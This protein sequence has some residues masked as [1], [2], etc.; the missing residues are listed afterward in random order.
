MAKWTE[1]LPGR[2]TACA[3][4]FV[5]AEGK[6]AGRGETAGSCLPSLGTWRLRSTGAASE[7]LCRTEMGQ[8]WREKGR[9]RSSEMGEEGAPLRTTPGLLARAVG[10][11]TRA[12]WR[13]PVWA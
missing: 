9:D 2:G 1:R 11:L 5:G 8:I 12:P 3:K 4:V 10:G 6:G 7:S 13:G